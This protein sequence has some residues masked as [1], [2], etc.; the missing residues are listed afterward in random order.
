MYTLISRSVVC[1]IASNCCNLVI[2]DCL[3]V[4][5]A[6]SNEN[7]QRK[8][9]R[10]INQQQ[11][12]WSF[13][14]PISLI[15]SSNSASRIAAFSCAPLYASH[16]SFTSIFKDSHCVSSSRHSVFNFSISYCIKLIRWYVYVGKMCWIASYFIFLW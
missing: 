15:S 4:V 6:F 9:E 3:S 8:K 2:I 1:C 5:F 13:D 14:L 16:A 7:I 12:R 11:K 10:K